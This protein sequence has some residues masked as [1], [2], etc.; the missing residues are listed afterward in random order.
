MAT[1]LLA[2]LEA[3]AAQILTGKPDDTMSAVVSRSEPTMIRVD[4]QKIKRIFGAEGEFTAIPD[5]DT[6]SAYIKPQTDKKVISLFVTD[7]AGR[8]WKLLLAVN[9]GP[10]ETIVIK[11]SGGA[12]AKAKYGQIA[13]RDT[14]RTQAI[15]RL[16]V[17]L[18]S[19]KDDEFGAEEK[20]EVVPL[21]AESMFVLKKVI[22]GPIR[23]EKYLLTNVSGKPMMIDERELY[24]RDVL[25]VAVEK[26]ELL[27]GET[28]AVY[29]VLE[30]G[31]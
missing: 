9:D 7:D 5:P 26:P 27:P 24:R 19:D 20:N 29:I 15:K 17:A 28:T 2:S 25:A 10:S 23:G 31:E 1:L 18:M 3:H 21:W 12:S 22:E 16:I 13:T 14:P 8:T 6:G 30:G 4:G 11:G